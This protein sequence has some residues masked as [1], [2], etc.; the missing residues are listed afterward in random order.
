M[1]HI[2]IWESVVL[3][4]TDTWMK[5]IFFFP[6]LPFVLFLSQLSR[7]QLIFKLPASACQFPQL[8]LFEE[9][10]FQ[11]SLGSSLLKVLIDFSIHATVI[12]IAA[13][14]KA[15]PRVREEAI[16][17]SVNLPVLVKQMCAYLDLQ[18]ESNYSVAVAF[19]LK[20]ASMSPTLW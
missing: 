14:G 9:N 12:K 17:I 2:N 6:N 1:F 11:E 3:G 4:F 18:L 8:R 13:K 19:L 7:E 10:T 15:K 20:E 5:D 16:H